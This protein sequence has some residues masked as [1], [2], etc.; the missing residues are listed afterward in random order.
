MT[1]AQNIASKPDPNR[2]IQTIINVHDKILN[3]QQNSLLNNYED[4]ANKAFLLYYGTFVKIE[5]YSVLLT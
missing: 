5:Q 4:F 2:V 1:W 3:T